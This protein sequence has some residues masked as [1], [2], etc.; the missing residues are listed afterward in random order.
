[1]MFAAIGFDFGGTLTPHLRDYL[2]ELWA[3]SMHQLLPAVLSEE[4][5][6][7]FEQCEDDYWIDPHAVLPGTAERLLELAA[8]RIGA[9]P[10]TGRLRRQLVARTCELMADAVPADSP[11]VDVF[12]WARG[13]GLRVG[14]LS[15][16]ILPGVCVTNWLQRQGVENGPDV[17]HVSSETGL[18]KPDPRAFECFSR[19]LG[20]EPAATVFV[21][22]DW[23]ED[24]LPAQR[25][26]YRVVHRWLTEA[27]SGPPVIRNSSLQRIE[28][29][30]E[31]PA[32]LS[33]AAE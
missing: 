17:L 28:D 18:V 32:L 8:E 2:T 27:P 16:L 4:L 23:E 7:A 6:Q 19:A 12:A 3:H 5:H 25:M 24:V 20:S 10:L 9:P 31:L 14:V 1:M 29:L 30:S 21:G 33:G 22:N 15:N 13:A 11:L 26:G